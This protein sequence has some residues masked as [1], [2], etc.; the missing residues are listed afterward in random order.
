MVGTDIVAQTRQALNNIV[1][2]LAEGGA[3]PNHI[4]RMNWYVVD[5]AAY[6]ASARELGRVYRE[7]IGDHYPAMTLLG[8]AGL[9]EPGALVEI[10]A[11]AAYNKC[12]KWGQTPL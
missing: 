5:M 7:I 6:T 8:V 11:T 10:E 12:N 4:A 3:A 2:I 9:V 1:D